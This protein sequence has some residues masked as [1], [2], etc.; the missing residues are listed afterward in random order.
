MIVDS[1]VHIW[2]ANSA[3]RPWKQ[4]AQPQRAIPL[5][6]EELLTEMNAAGVDR[7]V[8][9]PPSWEGERNDVA[10]AAAQANPDRFAVMGRLDPLDST[11]PSRLSDLLREPGMLG[12]RLTAQ[13]SPEMQSILAAGRLEWLWPELERLGAP[14]F[15]SV[16]H[17]MAS[18]VS[19][20][21]SRFPSLRIA[22][23]HIGLPYGTFDEEA[24]SNLDRVLTLSR[25]SNVAVKLSALPCYTRHPYPYLNLHPHLRRVHH[26]F[27]SQRMFWGSDLSRSPISYRENV[28]MVADEIKWLSNTDKEWILGRGVCQ[29]LNWKLN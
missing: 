13:M 6:A 26:A 4:N 21:A 15:L 10:L 11:S 2:A 29:W 19:D 1:V 28:A 20:I 5:G 18:L 8:L 23:D 25:Y 22:L 3:D 24:L 16:P 9:V 14:V 17:A 27:G 7:V 12:L